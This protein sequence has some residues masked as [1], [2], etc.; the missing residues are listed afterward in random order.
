M[1]KKPI[2]P[3][4]SLAEAGEVLALQKEY[5]GALAQDPEFALGDAH[6]EIKRAPEF[7]RKWMPLADA[8]E[9]HHRP[10]QIMIGM[11]LLRI[12]RHFEKTSDN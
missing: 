4:F 2:N 11:L 6:V 1:P 5:L 8:E 3:N 10:H 9:P 12:E 7:I